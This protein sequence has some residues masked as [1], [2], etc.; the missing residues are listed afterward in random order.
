MSHKLVG[1]VVLDTAP[2][3]A[4]ICASRLTPLDKPDAGVRPVVI[5]EV[6]Q[7]LRQGHVSNTAK[8]NILLPT[9]FGIG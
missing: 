6:L 5:S 7:A 1:F 3:Q 4:T 9:P 2:G 8:A